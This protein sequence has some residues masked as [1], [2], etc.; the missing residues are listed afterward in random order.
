MKIDSLHMTNWEENRNLVLLI[1]LV[2]T[3]VKDF[4]IKINDSSSVITV[5]VMVFK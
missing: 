3:T 2:T 5:S 4:I 1:T